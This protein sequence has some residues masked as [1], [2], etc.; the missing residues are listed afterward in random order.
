LHSLDPRAVLRRGYA[1]V[2]RAADGR[3]V[4]SVQQVQ[5][6]MPLD[7][8]VSDGHFQARAEDGPNAPDT[9]AD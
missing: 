8:T 5:P 4:D 3:L 2:S 9:P 7:I 6:G 1:I